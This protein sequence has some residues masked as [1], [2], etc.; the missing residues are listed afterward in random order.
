MAPPM[1]SAA[2]PAPA[3]GGGNRR[4]PRARAVGAGRGGDGAVGRV[5]DPAAGGSGG[6]G[7]DRLLLPRASRGR[8]R[9]GDRD[10]GRHHAAVGALEAEA[11][12]EG[13]DDARRGDGGRPSLAAALSTASANAAAVGKRS[14]G[15]AASA[16][17]DDRRRRHQGRI[18]PSPRAAWAGVPR[19]ICSIIAPSLSP[20]I[21]RWPV[22]SSHR[23]APAA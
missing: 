21:R 22:R 15:E 17:M 14:A 18:G 12:D 16:R 19:R 20:R 11:L 1:T 4:A 2:A 13:G 8:A 10:A 23:S 9:R 3:T 7:A 6:R 5:G